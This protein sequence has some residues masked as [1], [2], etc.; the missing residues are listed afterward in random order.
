MCLFAAG[1]VL[2]VGLS[3]VWVAPQVQ[4]VPLWLGSGELGAMLCLVC[5]K[6]LLLLLLLLLCL[7][8]LY[9]SRTWASCWV[10]FCGL[11]SVTDRPVI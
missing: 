4:W 11:R 3:E 10:W 8:Y 7:W 5:G 2:M 6:V 1:G 9:R